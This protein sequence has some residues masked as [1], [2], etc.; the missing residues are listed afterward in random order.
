MRHLHH[1]T[2]NP[3]GLF[4]P[5]A[6]TD[7][8][9]G[10]RPTTVRVTLDRDA[11]GRHQHRRHPLDPHPDTHMLRILIDTTPTWISAGHLAHRDCY[12]CEHIWT[13]RYREHHNN[14]D[15]AQFLHTTLDLDGH[16]QQV[17]LHPEEIPDHWLTTQEHRHG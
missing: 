10:A 13:Q 17:L 5:A 11:D 6:F 3:H 14:P 8:S 16:D 4:I 7:D 1:I 2:A 15:T 12:D 9:A